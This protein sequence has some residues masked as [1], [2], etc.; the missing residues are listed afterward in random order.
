MFLYPNFM[1]MN[2]H[3]IYLNLHHSSD[4]ALLTINISIDEEFIQKE[5]W[6][7]INDSKEEKMFIVNFIK[8]VGNLDTTDILNKD[9]LEHLV[10][11]Y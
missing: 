1:E 11:I 10:L 9:V 8:K 2:N 3:S 6:T 7:I 5:C 4:H